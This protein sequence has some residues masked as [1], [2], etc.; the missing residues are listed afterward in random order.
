MRYLLTI[1]VF[2]NWHVLEVLGNRPGDYR[3]ATPALAG[4]A[5]INGDHGPA[6]KVQSLKRH[7]A[8]SILP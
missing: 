7:I 6:F 3:T 1:L 8:H 5:E 4:I 2:R